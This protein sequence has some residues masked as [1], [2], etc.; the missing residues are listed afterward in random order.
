MW[1]K[2]HSDL[3]EGWYPLTPGAPG[4]L[5]MPVKLQAWLGAETKA[6]AHPP[7]PLP[8][9]HLLRTGLE[10]D[11]V[12]RAARKPSRSPSGARPTELWRSRNQSSPKGL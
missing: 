1:G 6:H 8:K 9:Q 2:L 12:T 11:P 10:Q 5:H 4:G 7:S 3:W